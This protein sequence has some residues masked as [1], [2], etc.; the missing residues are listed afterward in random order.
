MSLGTRVETH[1][2]RTSEQRLATRGPLDVRRRELAA[3]AA[4]TASSQLNRRAS[5]IHAASPYS[6]VSPLAI[7]TFESS[8]DGRSGATH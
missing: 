4:A 5:N 6:F 1:A 3:A 8:T 2:G 7:I